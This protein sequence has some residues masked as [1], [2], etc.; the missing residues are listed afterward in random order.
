MGRQVQGPFAHLGAVLPRHIRARI[1]DSG[2]GFMFGAQFIRVKSMAAA[3][4]APGH[5]SLDTF[6]SA[7]SVSTNK[8]N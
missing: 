8:G 7:P 5:P 1:P 2:E 4:A 3:M 6:Q